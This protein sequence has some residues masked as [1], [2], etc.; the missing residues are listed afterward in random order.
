MK[1]L[2][3]GIPISKNTMC[4][5]YLAHE[6]VIDCACQICARLDEKSPDRPFSKADQE[7]V[8]SAATKNSACLFPIAT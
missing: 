8:F 4:W 6:N 2:R 1:R 7:I 5:E 3:R